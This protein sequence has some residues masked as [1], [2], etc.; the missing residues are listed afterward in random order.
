MQQRADEGMG[1]LSNVGIPERVVP[2]E[3]AIFRRKVCS[4]E[5]MMVWANFLML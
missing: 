4:R 5:P 2:L 3:S 1:Q